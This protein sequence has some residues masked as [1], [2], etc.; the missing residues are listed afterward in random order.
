MET[1]LSKSTSLVVSR[2][3]DFF[4]HRRPWHRRLWNIGTHLALREVLEY[5][6]ACLS[7]AVHST[8]GL[9]FVVAAAQREAGRDPGVAPLAAEI[10]SCLS[11]LSVSSRSQIPVAARDELAH[12]IRR[13]EIEYLDN[14]CVT[15]NNPSVE[16][17]AR[18]FASHL[19]DLGFSPDHLYRWT[20]KVGPRITNL[21]ELA[22]ATRAM[23]ASMPTRTYEVFVP[24]A[25]PYNKSGVNTGPVKWL[26]GQTAATWLHQRLPGGE[27]R[28]LSGG[29]DFPS[30]SATKTVETFSRNDSGARSSRTTVRTLGVQQYMM[31]PSR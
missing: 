25:A 18:A 3:G 22:D 20:T 10:D 27:A 11:R 24:C 1:P 31:L 28:R 23:A 16:F 26:P 6:D 19:L 21:A 13:V 8:E 4:A 9:K 30:T 29:F 2:L 12:L 15:T 7:E 17:S 5:A 14:W